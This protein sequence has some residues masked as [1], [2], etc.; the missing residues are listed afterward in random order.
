MKEIWKVILDDY[1][2]EETPSIYSI[3]NKG[4]VRNNL[5][6]KILNPI[7]H[8]IQRDLQVT[9]YFD[10]IPM[11]KKVHRLVAEA[12]IPNPEGKLFVRHK[13]YDKTNNS[14]ENLE[15]VTMKEARYYLRIRG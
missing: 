9:L 15:W 8:T 11:G 14:V 12:F 6:G 13:D 7:P 3:S 4:R 1:Y 5:T 10:K 2:V